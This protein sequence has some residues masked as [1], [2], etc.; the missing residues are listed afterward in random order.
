MCA[1]AVQ[2]WLEATACELGQGDPLFPRIRRDVIY[3]ESMS[4]RSLD[5]LVKK[6][7]VEAGFEEHEFSTHS[8]RAG[9]ATFLLDEGVELMRVQDHLRHKDSKTTRGYYRP[10][11]RLDRDP[12]DGLL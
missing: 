10:E 6:A 7:A 1:G 5:L 11:N 3:R 9:C 4:L 8:L 2:A 12:M